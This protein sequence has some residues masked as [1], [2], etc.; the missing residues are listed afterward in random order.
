MALVSLSPLP[1]AHSGVLG[2]CGRSGVCVL[3]Y[4]TL[5]DL[6]QLGTSSGRSALNSE[7]VFSVVPNDPAAAVGQNRNLTADPEL[8]QDDLRYQE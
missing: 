2:V 8:H 7:P 1:R 5:S 6:L 4:K 3:A